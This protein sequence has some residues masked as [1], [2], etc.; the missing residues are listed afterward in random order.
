MT[1]LANGIMEIVLINLR[2]YIHPVGQYNNNN[3]NND[4]LRKWVNYGKKAGWK[5]NR[6]IFVCMI[7]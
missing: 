1:I 6:Y 4:K 2:W 3:F 7:D 5:G